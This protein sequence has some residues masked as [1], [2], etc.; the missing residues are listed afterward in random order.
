[1]KKILY[2]SYFFPPINTIATYRALYT[3]K[4]LALNGYKVDVLC[5]IG[6]EQNLDNNLSKELKNLKNVN[7]Y[8]IKNLDIIEKMIN[9]KN[10]KDNETTENSK[11]NLNNKWKNIYR[12][13]L[14]N[15][16]PSNYKYIPDRYF[17][18]LLKSFYFYKKNL[19]SNKY[20]AIIS[21]FGPPSV[22][23][24][25]YRIKKN[26]NTVWIADYRDLWSNEHL[27]NQLKIL[28]FINK[29]IEKFVVRNANYI[30]TVS[31]FLVQELKS[32]F[33]KHYINVIYNGYE[34]STIPN[35]LKK[36]KFIVSYTGTIYEGKRDPSNFFKA[37][38][39][40]KKEGIINKDNFLIYY[41]GKDGNKFIK[42]SEKFGIDDLI[43]NLGL[44]SHKD[45]I[46]LQVS[47]DLLLLL[48][49]NN[50]KAKG[51]L[52]G[53]LFEY[54][55]ARKP[56]LFI[57]YKGSEINDI[58]SYTRSGKCLNDPSEI[59]NYIIKIMNKE[60]TFNFQNVEEFS[61]ENQTKKFIKLIEGDKW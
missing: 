16:L 51:V 34:S 28:K 48:E 31:N 26:C 13:I 20:D 2:I 59:K 1:M 58:L 9:Y 17:I 10:K 25:A 15:F 24:L 41:A 21:S 50:P 44:I 33:P 35:S 29:L 47:S 3:V 49:W 23:I 56:I 7:I 60:I 45:S 5:G 22:H 57:G 46:N 4:Y 36:D 12:F 11:S 54:L 38:L 30:T 43:K 42:L 52:T 61:R 40:L 55:Y 37:V 53:K 39:M 32:L 6:D 19:I 8:R 18:W 27:N 14:T